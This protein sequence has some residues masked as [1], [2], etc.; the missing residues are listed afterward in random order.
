MEEE[1]DQHTKAAHAPGAKGAREAGVDWNTITIALVSTLALLVLAW[2]SNAAVQAL[3]RSIDRHAL[4][5]LARLQPEA[6][7]I[8]AAAKLKGVENPNGMSYGCVGAAAAAGACELRPLPSANVSFSIGVI[9]ALARCGAVQGFYDHRGMLAALGGDEEMAGYLH[10]LQSEGDSGPP[11]AEPRS[12]NSLDTVLQFLN[13]TVGD[14]SPAST[15]FVPDLEITVVDTYPDWQPPGPVCSP[16]PDA[17]GPMEM[18]WN[19]LNAKARYAVWL[20]LHQSAG[21]AACLAR[22]LAS[23]H[24]C[25]AADD[26]LYLVPFRL[27]DHP[28]MYLCTGAVSASYWDVWG[29]VQTATINIHRKAFLGIDSNY[30]D[31]QSIYAG[32]MAA[33]FGRNPAL[34]H[35]ISS[36][37]APLLVTACMLRLLWQS[38]SPDPTDQSAPTLAGAFAIAVAA[39]LILGIALFPRRQCVISWRRAKAGL[40]A[41]G[42]NC[43]SSWRQW[44]KRRAMAQTHP[45]QAAKA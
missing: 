30:N 14:G 26:L 5:T 33:V 23:Q 42:K 32:A 6:I 7:C 45:P 28:K 3:G 17:T 4:L 10:A 40:A 41:F 34:L 11:P 35:V 16:L 36:G 29:N 9:R 43:A 18:V 13:D 31:L 27:E 15:T 39:F 20:K 25:T 19:L 21:T 12:G 8:N 38:H 37:S 1:R 2:R 24:L 44:R 22:A